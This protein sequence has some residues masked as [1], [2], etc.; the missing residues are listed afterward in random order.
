MTTF[1]GGSEDPRLRDVRLFRYARS[2]KD[3]CKGPQK[4]SK[5]VTFEDFW[6]LRSRSEI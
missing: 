3:L 2:K 5:M 1:E 4:G 6:T